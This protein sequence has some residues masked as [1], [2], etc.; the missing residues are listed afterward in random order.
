MAPPATLPIEA[1]QLFFAGGADL[2]VDGLTIRAYGTNPPA[3][4]LEIATPRIFTTPPKFFLEGVG[5]ISYTA[6]LIGDIPVSNTSPSQL[7]QVWANRF[8]ASG[9][10]FPACPKALNLW[11]GSIIDVK[12]LSVGSAVIISTHNE[13]ANQSQGYAQVTQDVRFRYVSTAG[14]PVSEVVLYMRDTNHGKRKHYQLCL[15]SINNL[16][17]NVYIA[18]SSVSGDALLSTDTGFTKSVLL[19]AVAHLVSNADFLNDVGENAKDFRSVSGVAGGDD[20]HFYHHSYESQHTSGIVSIK[21]DLTPKDVSVLLFSD[22]T[23]TL[24][25]AAALTRL[26]SNFIVNTSTHTI[27]VVASSTLDDLYDCLKVWKCSAVQ[28]QLE[29]PTIGTYPV[30][31][32][33]AVLSTT[34]SI[35]I[36]SGVS[37][38]SGA[39]LKSLISSRTISLAVVSNVSGVISVPY[40]DVNGVYCTISGLDPAGLGTT[41]VLGYMTQNAYL[42]RNTAQPPSAWA[43]F[44]S[45]SGT[46]ATK[47]LTLLPNTKYQL[48]YCSPGYEDYGSVPPISIDTATALTATFSPQ[49]VRDIYGQV[50]WTQTASYA[51]DA[52]RFSITSG[53]F[54]YTNASTA[55]Q[56]HRL[57]FYRAYELCY[58]SQA[59]AFTV[60]KHLYLSPT[61]DGMIVPSSNPFS[62]RMSSASTAGATLC[63]DFL[64]ETTL[65]KA[66]SRFL[67]NSAHAYLLMPVIP[68]LG[69]T[70]AEI[71]GSQILALKAHVDEV[72]ANITAARND[73]ASVGT[74]VNLVMEDASV[75]ADNTAAL[76]NDLSS[77]NGTVSAINVTVGVVN[78]TTNAINTTV[79]VVNSTTNAINT[80][81]GDVNGTVSAINLTVSAVNA[82]VGSVNQSIVAVCSTLDS[83][84][85][86]FS[87]LNATT[88]T[89]GGINS[90]VGGMNTTLANVTDTLACVSSNVASL[91]AQPSVSDINVTLTNVSLAVTNIQRDI[92]VIQDN[93]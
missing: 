10:R 1:S 76:L 80:T 47:S 75:A 37:L 22:T 15:Q 20:F 93:T 82:T 18:S 52:S 54:E 5:G 81:I 88:S 14:N 3:A 7:R 42:A 65:A 64:F 17:D 86:T 11:L 53:V 61:R 84:N 67:A 51:T 13:S 2:V 35:V 70:L 58:K 8:R 91:A 68:T 71:E 59:V 29:Y 49:A 77:V 89:I 33:G 32:N 63:L 73:V 39:K 27:T 41:W 6:G 48:F 24:S 50:I 46:G 87:T 12:N 62:A 31:A 92:K 23:V 16:A 38:T 36:N 30:T 85:G 21:N 83:M 60:I 74:K 78:S 40:Q 28:A 25:R 44:S 55:D 45:V 57:A 72:L 79:G 34:M 26:A 56:V 4:V 69:A 9:L 66:Y 43:G 19:C 90:T